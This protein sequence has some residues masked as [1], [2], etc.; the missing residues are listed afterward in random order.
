MRRVESYSEDYSAYGISTT[1]P[2]PQTGRFNTED[3][4]GRISNQNAEDLETSPAFDRRK[5]EQM[6]L[7]IG[8]NVKRDEASMA[9]KIGR[10][11][12]RFFFSDETDRFLRRIG[13]FW[14]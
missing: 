5:T 12:Y 2:R 13:R 3:M 7:T 10:V 8:A 6:A 9:A 1:S 14:Q 4:S 11:P